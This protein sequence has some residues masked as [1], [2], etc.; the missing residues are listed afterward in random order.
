MV[1]ARKGFTG[2]TEALVAARPDL[3]VRIGFRARLA[4]RLPGRSGFRRLG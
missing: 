1:F 4:E 3:R 2:F